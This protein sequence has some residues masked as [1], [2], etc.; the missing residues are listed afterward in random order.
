VLGAVFDRPVPITTNAGDVLAGANCDVTYR[1]ERIGQ[2]ALECLSGVTGE[3]EAVI[4]GRLSSRG[5]RY[6][7]RHAERLP[8][9][10]AARVLR[11][12]GAFR[13]AQE[14]RIE[15]TPGAGSRSSGWPGLA[16]C[17]L[18]VSLATAGAL[19]VRR[20]GGPLDIL[21]SPVALTV[22]VTVTAYG[23]LRLR[24]AAD[25]ALILLGAVGAATVLH[26]F[27]ARHSELPG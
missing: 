23:T 13:P 21:L 5:L 17:W 18:L 3:N 12:W 4:A 16:A 1:G 25:I 27:P 26:R 19:A 9:V 15:S 14:L 20:R 24:A 6:A 10:A 8:A 22:V 2:W 11:P 7:R